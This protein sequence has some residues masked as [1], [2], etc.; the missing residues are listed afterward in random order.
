MSA[1]DDLPVCSAC[2]KTM[3]LN[4]ERV[5]EESGILLRHRE[6]REIYAC[7]CGNKLVRYIS[8][9]PASGAV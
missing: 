3:K 7:S 8:W 9:P 5:S 4:E 2:G 1:K 6:I